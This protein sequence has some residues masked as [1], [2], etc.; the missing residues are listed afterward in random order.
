MGKKDMMKIYFQA[1][2]FGCLI[3]TPT[4]PIITESM[5]Y[6]T[7]SEEEAVYDRS[8]RIRCNKNQVRNGIMLQ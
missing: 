4:A 3:A 6:F 2:K 5:L 7:N 8:Y 1:Q